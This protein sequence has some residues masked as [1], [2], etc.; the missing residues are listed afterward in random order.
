MTCSRWLITLNLAYHW[1]LLNLDLPIL[2]RQHKSAPCAPLPDDFK[3]KDHNQRA[4]RH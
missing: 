3:H 4:A 2:V 1:N